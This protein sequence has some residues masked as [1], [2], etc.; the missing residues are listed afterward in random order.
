MN[1]KEI[2]KFDI[3][4]HTYIGTYEFLTTDTIRTNIL[5]FN[6]KKYNNKDSVYDVNLES[7]SNIEYIKYKDFC[8]KYFDELL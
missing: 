4:D 7:V 2:I 5:L 1:E 6:Y 8:V 3:G